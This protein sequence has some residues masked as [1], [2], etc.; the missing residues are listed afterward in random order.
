[1]KSL[2]KDSCRPEPARQEFRK[3][4]VKVS[5]EI[6]KIGVIVWNWKNDRYLWHAK[7]HAAAKKVH[8][9]KLHVV[10]FAFNVK[11]VREELVVDVERYDWEGEGLYLYISTHELYVYPTPLNMN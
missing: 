8:G 5:P 1:M 4:P 3:R 10:I 2:P 11:M 9:I 6:S 7:G